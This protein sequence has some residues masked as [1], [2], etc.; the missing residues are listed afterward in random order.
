MKTAIALLAAFFAVNAAGQNLP[1]GLEGEMVEIPMI[2]GDTVTMYNS[3]RD[4]H[5][6]YPVMLAF[7]HSKNAVVWFANNE[8]T[9]MS[10]VVDTPYRSCMIYSTKCLVPTV[11]ASSRLKIFRRCLK[12]ESEEQLRNM[13]GGVTL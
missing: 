10:I 8:G 2:C 6:E 3:L 9:S 4:T 12:E 1:E 11:I 13:S 5:G 7:S